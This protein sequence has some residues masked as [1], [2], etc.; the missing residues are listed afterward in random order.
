MDAAVLS[1]LKTTLDQRGPDAA[2][3]ELCDRLRQRKDYDNLFYARLLAG[4]HRLGLVPIP[5]ASVSEIPPAQQPAFEDTIRTACREVGSLYLA[6]GN[7][8]QAWGY[9]RMIDEREPVLQALG[10]Y[11]PEPG[12]EQLDSLIQ[13]A[14]YEGLLPRTGFDWVLQH[15][16]LCNAVTVLSGRQLPMTPEDRHHCVGRV[17]DVLYDELRDRIATDIERREGQLPPEASAPKGERGVV[18]AMIAKRPE[19]F[20]DDNYHIDFSHLS[21]AVQMSLELPPGS[22]LD[23]A[24]ELCE[25][26][27][28]LGGSYRSNAEPPFDDQYRDQRIY[29]NAIAGD[30][31]EEG[32]AHFR[33][34]AD[35]TT[36]D[37]SGTGPAEVLVQLLLRLGRPQEAVA[38]AAKHLAPVDLPRLAFTAE[39][40][41]KAKDYATLAEVAR[42]QGNAVQYLAG[43]LA[44]S[45]NGHKPS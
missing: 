12:D 8:A 16:S 39:L 40:C 20:A 36:V 13:L 10:A 31:V 7:V 3:A 32:V 42:E 18:R 41:Q 33:N 34:K 45:S 43:L 11:R 25:Y 37:E 29:L 9:Y 38:V 6:E 1:E 30:N 14:L 35:S 15:G 5:T 21:M 27:E 44:Q 28:N 26:G 22:A 4:R 2:I 17:L 23:T 19:L 24:R